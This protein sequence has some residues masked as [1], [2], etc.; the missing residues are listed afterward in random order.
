[1]SRQNENDLT[2][3]LGNIPRKEP[4]RFL[5]ATVLIGIDSRCQGMKRKNS[6]QTIGINKSSDEDLIRMCSP[7]D[8]VER[9][10]RLIE[11]LRN[12]SGVVFDSQGRP[13]AR[14]IKNAKG[15]KPRRDE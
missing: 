5:M 9:R 8:G 14:M 10:K 3:N 1:M 6:Y 2:W 4:R 11:Q 7:D 12:A 13:R 15:G